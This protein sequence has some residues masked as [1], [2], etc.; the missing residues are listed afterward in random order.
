MYLSQ[1][2]VMLMVLC[3]EIMNTYVSANSAHLSKHIGERVCSPAN[4]S[5]C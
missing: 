1:K 2:G 5:Y 4:Q 3:I